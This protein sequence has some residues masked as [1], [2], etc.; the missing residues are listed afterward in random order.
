MNVCKRDMR[1]ICACIAVLSFSRSAYAMGLSRDTDANVPV[2]VIRSHSGLDT[3]APVGLSLTRIGRS[4]VDVGLTIEGPW[5][6][7]INGKSYQQM[8]LDTFNNWQYVTYYDQHQRL[9]IARRRLPDGPWEVIHFDDYLFKGNDNHN[10]TVLGICPSDGTIHLAFDHHGDPLHYRVS[11]SGAAGEP[12]KVA[13]TAELFSE[14]RD[15][16][17]P[18][19]KIESVTYPRFVRVARGNLLFVRRHG[20]HLDGRIM[21]CEY[22][23]AKGGWSESWQVTDPSGAYEFEGTRSTNRNAYLNGVHFDYVRGRL[24][25]SWHW[26]EGGGFGVAQ[27][28]L[29]YAYSSDRGRTWFNS[30]GGRIGGPGRFIGIDTPGLAVWKISPARGL[31]NQEGQCVDARGRPHVMTWHVRQGEPDL[32]PGTKNE[33]QSAYYHYWREADGTWRR[34]EL[35]YPV[36]KSERNRPKILSTPNSDLVGMFNIQGK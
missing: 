9:S 25:L 16:L 31:D 30:A 2:S 15:W 12:E 7:F 20:S 17:R 3:P 23:P 34:I 4:K 22:V 24:H 32:K 28:E 10:V 19:R 8:P 21:L 27:H 11:K 35:P 13:W 33:A 29:N 26:R 14:V 18:G 1:W 6:T 5:G 36:D